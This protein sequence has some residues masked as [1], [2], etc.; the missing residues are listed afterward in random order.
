MRKQRLKINNQGLTN[1]QLINGKSYWLFSNNFFIIQLQSDVNNIASIEYGNIT[2][3]F[4]Y[5]YISMKIYGITVCTCSLCEALSCLR[6]IHSICTKSHMTVINGCHFF[7]WRKIKLC[8]CNCPNMFYAMW[9]MVLVWRTLIT[10][11]D[12]VIKWKHFPRYWPFVRGIHRS[13]R[14]VTRSFDAFF[15]LRLNKRLS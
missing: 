2:E 13:P 6:H 7:S 15:D 9:Y 5:F 8:L 3:A 10:I 1:A 4:P 12:D 11:H 14:P